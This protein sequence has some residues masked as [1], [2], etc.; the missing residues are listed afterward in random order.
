M[1]KITNAN[2]SEKANKM[3]D[4]KFKDYRTGSFSAADFDNWLGTTL[5]S[6]TI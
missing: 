3:M 5:S 6:I 2:E 4:E 1:A